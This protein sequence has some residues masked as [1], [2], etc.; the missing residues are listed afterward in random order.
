VSHWVAARHKPSAFEEKTT[1][2]RPALSGGDDAPLVLIVDDVEES[3]DTFAD[4]FRR[5]GLRVTTAV[6]GE[7][8]LLKVMSMLPD[9]VVMDLALPI[10]DGWEAMRRI[11]ANDKTKHIPIIAITGHGSAENVKR[12][13]VAGADAVVTKPCSAQ[14]L[15]TLTLQ[16]LDRARRA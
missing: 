7:H 11:K 2:T 8:A 9:I 1:G 13:E 16:F 10:I 3:R 6:D 4:L 14:S 5:A 15:L 12:A